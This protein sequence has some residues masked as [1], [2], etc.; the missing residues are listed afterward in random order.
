MTARNVSIDARDVPFKKNPNEPPRR[1]PS[2]HLWRKR[3]AAEYFKG[4]LIFQYA[5]STRGEYDPEI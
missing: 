1:V 2:L 5:L 4:R 3:Q